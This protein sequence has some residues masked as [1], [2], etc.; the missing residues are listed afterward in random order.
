MVDVQAGTNSAS[1]PSSGG[2]STAGRPRVV[3]SERNQPVTTI[4]SLYFRVK[5]EGVDLGSFTKCEGL[6]CEMTVMQRE[7]GGVNDFVHQLPGRMKFS[8][9]TLTRPVSKENQAASQNVAKWLASVAAKPKRTTAQIEAL[10]PVGQ[11]LFSWSLNGVIPVKWKGPS[12]DVESAKVA[13]ETL[14]LA[15]NGFLAA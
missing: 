6:G 13:V 14:E 3:T 5:I 12:F 11:P 2:S 1:A 8:N 9:I 4:I 7:E 15:H 10:D